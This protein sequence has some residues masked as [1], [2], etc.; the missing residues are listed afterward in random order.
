M[1]ASMKILERGTL[2]FGNGFAYRRTEA[3][4]ISYEIGPDAQFAQ[5]IRLTFT[6][7]GRRKPSTQVV[8]SGQL[9]II[10]GWG[11]PVPPD[12]WSKGTPLGPMPMDWGE[13]TATMHHT[14]Y[15]LGDLRWIMEFD[16]F[17][18]D[19]IR[20]SGAQVLLDFREH[21]FKEAHRPRFA[22]ADLTPDMPV[23][24]TGVVQGQIVPVDQCPNGEIPAQ[25][26]PNL[27]E[28]QQLFPDLDLKGSS[29]RFNGPTVDKHRGRWRSRFDS[30]AV[31]ERLSR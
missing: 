26:F 22:S 19:Y 23:I 12:D 27:A 31:Y 7:K 2:Y 21:D 10:A 5:A 25:E 20:R 16:A 14:R 13:V 11:H 24:V 28:A 1:S 3:R 15:P 4:Q 30:S 29:K 6:H 9:V 17:L 8:I 18:Q